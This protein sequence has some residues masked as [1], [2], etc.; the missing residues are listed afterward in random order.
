MPL[1]AQAETY[2]LMA[3]EQGCYWCGRWNEEIGPIYPKTTEG[4]SAPLRR[5]DL[6]NDDVTADLKAEYGSHLHLY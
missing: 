2:L 3:E 5:Y 4:Q 6:Y 1:S